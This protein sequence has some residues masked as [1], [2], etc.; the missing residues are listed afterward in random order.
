MDVTFVGFTLVD[1]PNPPLR[2]QLVL[3]HIF[4]KLKNLS[5]KYQFTPTPIL[6]PFPQPTPIN[7]KIIMPILFNS[8]KAFIWA[9]WS[10]YYVI[11]YEPNAVWYHWLLKKDN[12][13]SGLQFYLLV[14]M[15]IEFM[16]YSKLYLLLPRS[17]EYRLKPLSPLSLLH[18][19]SALSF[20]FSRLSFSMSFYCLEMTSLS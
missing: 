7:P 12:S 9:Y 16:L 10:S 13:P 3:N 11:L 2:F 17:R 15:F 4:Y 8:F 18:F 19:F 6:A 1:E 5:K 14:D 20:S